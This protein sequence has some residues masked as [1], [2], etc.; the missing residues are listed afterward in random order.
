MGELIDKTKGA[1][2]DGIGKA[3]EK[4]GRANNDPALEAEGHAQQATGK[5]QKLKGTVKGALGDNV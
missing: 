3:K 4:A 5:G 2:N 1:I